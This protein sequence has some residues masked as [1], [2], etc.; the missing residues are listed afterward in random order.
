MFR[1]A[2]ALAVS[3]LSLLILSASV[4]ATT[5][6]VPQDFWTVQAAGAPVGSGVYFVHLEATRVR[7]TERVILRR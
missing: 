3:L 4:H 7:A 1:R 6:R 2:A 5:I